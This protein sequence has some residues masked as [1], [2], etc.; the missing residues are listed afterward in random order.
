MT[1]IKA[2][3]DGKAL[4]LDEP[5]HLPTDVPLILHVDI[6][7]TTINQDVEARPER[8]NALDEGP[9]RFGFIVG[10]YD[11]ADLT[12]RH[13]PVS[14]DWTHG[15]VPRSRLRIGQLFARF[16]L[17][18]GQVKGDL[19]EQRID[20]ERFRQGGIRISQLLGLVAQIAPG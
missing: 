15:H 9:N 6:P 7:L 4:V 13:R 10:R 1:T 2:H 19:R 16:A 11:D 20:V 3:F 14:D 5:V 18:A 8:Q 17:S 12:V